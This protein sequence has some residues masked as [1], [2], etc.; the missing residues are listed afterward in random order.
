LPYSISLR[1][2]GIAAL[3]M[4]NPRLDIPSQ[5]FAAA[6]SAVLGGDAEGVQCLIDNGLVRKFRNLSNMFRTQIRLPI[7]GLYFN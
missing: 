3:L 7:L 2:H 6:T 4:Q 1:E 5:G